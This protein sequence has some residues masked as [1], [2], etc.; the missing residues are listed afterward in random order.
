MSLKIVRDW[1]NLGPGERGAA[2]ALGNFDGVHLGHQRVIAAAAEAARQTGAP[3][4]VVSFEPHPRVYFQ[5]E[6]EPF[7]VMSPGQQA[8]ALAALGV[9]LFYE[10]P[11]AAE[12]AGMSDAR[13]VETVLV[14]GLG[15]T[16]VAV[17]F[18]VTYGKG[19]TGGPQELA[20]AGREQGFGVSVVERVDDSGG[21]KLS[22]TA[23]RDALHAGRPE[24]AAAILGRPFAIE[25]EVVHGDKRGRQIGVPTANVRLGDYVRPKYGVY[26]VRSRLPDGR[27][28]DGVANLGVRPMFES[29]EPLLEV[30][31]FDFEGDLYGQVIE[32]ELAA[33]LRP[34]MSFDSLDALKRQI[35]EDAARARKVLAL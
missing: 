30:W 31:L 16:W 6:A 35:D 2:V 29:P 15:V 10:L 4:G 17:G 23:V 27:V 22:S 34:E 20:A 12:M 9:E 32:T 25:G 21:A 3:L 8:R 5:P 19:R 24:Q 13:F 18:D 11:F 26:A 28:V 1:R 7:R 14:Q 33:Y